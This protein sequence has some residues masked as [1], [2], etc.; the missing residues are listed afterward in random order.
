MTLSEVIVSALILGISSKVSLDGWASTTA[1]AARSE[2][3]QQHLQ[4]LDQQMLSAER[5]LAH[6]SVD[7]DH[8]RFSGDVVPDLQ[9]RLPATALLEQRFELSSSEKGIWLVLQLSD[10]TSVLERRVLFTP[11]GLGLCKQSKA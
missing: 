1:W 2:Q 3:R 4:Q 11:A 10:E 8:C 9:E 7:P 6:A 5:L